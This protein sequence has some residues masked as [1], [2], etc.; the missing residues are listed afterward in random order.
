[1]GI[2]MLIFIIGLAL[3]ADVIHII[4]Q[5]QKQSNIILKQ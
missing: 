3:F 2:L 5:E 1:M 4:Y